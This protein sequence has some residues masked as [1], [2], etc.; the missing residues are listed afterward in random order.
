MINNPKQEKHVHQ[1][2]RKTIA[3]SLA[4]PSPAALFWRGLLQA[5]CPT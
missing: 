1:Y 2:L 3:V 5:T 4:S